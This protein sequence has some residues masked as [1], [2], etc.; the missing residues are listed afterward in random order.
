V[1]PISRQPP[2]VDNAGMPFPARSGAP[3]LGKI[4]GVGLVL[5]DTRTR[6]VRP[7]EPITA[8]HVGIYLC[9]PTVQS[10]PHVGHLRGA[11]VVDVLRRWLLASG[12]AV[13]LV[14]NVTDID[15]KIITNAAA[16]GQSP[17]AL[18][19]RF[20][21]EFNRAYDLVGVLAPTIEP[22]ATGHIPEMIELV[23]RLIDRG[24]AYSTG[25][26]VWFSVASFP[27]YG[28]LSGQRPDS[29]QPSPEG[30]GGKRDPRDFAL[31]KAAK[32]GE[33]TWPTPWG[34]G[35]PGWHLECSSMAAKYLGSQFDVHGGG[36]D[37]IFPHHENERAQ[38]DCGLDFDGDP[39]MARCWMHH[40]LL[41]VAGGEKMSK[42]LGNAF[43]IDDVLA[44]TRPQALRYYLLAAHYRSA[45]EYG[46][47]QLA[48]ASAAYERLEGFLA[49]SSGGS[50]DAD[51][52]A[53]D[54]GVDH[55]W[56]AFA[57]A[58]DDDLAT[59][60]ALALVHEAVTE[61]HRSAD[62]HHHHR[63]VRR[64]LG[65]LGLDPISQWPPAA[66]GNLQPVLDHLV[67]AALERRAEARRRK[68]WAASD[69]I[70][71]ELAAA[72]ILVED[73]PQGQRWQLA[74]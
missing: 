24:H 26:G 67:G 68:D 15:D 36:L 7:F 33:P 63:L 11:V 18:A 29:L 19:E 65:V 42:S 22:R 45:V 13:T 8:G 70:R 55:H 27:G 16:A 62:P 72:G 66:G 69:G 5:Y 39:E 38:S 53:L 35:R 25:G 31:W 12:Y 28:G 14:R 6:R 58:M 52:A 74:R 1:T 44:G 2:A 51:D 10:A 37:L 48:E 49:R 61:G 46:P 73:T 32:P 43:L 3:P 30:E 40:G 59:P 4:T 21:R 23:Q 50:P 60:R 57:E 47:D 64:M 9:G 54:S 17:F 34:D 41:N 56:K 20:T 71:D